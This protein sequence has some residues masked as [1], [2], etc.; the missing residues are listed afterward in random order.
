MLIIIFQEYLQQLDEIDSDLIKELL[1]H[2][3]LLQLVSTPMYPHIINYI[4]T[5][6]IP[7]EVLEPVQYTTEWAITELL[8]ANFV[9]EA[10]HLRLV[11]LRVPA[12]L[13]GF[14]QSVLF[15]KDIINKK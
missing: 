9:A 14:N 1:D 15:Y 7:G 3:M 2:N 10:G 11:T 4:L 6:E 12:S 8:K 5:M 13:L